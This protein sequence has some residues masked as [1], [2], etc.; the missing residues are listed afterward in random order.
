MKA[1]KN[2]RH[3]SLPELEQYFE[4]LGEKKFRA[5]QV[6]EWIWQKHA[7]DFEGMTNLSKELR[8]KLNEHFSYPALAVNTTQYSSDGTIKSRFKTADNHFVEGVLIPTANR[9]TA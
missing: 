7:R 2:I 4:Q 1:A 6:Y 5:K 9:Q 8:V 3:L